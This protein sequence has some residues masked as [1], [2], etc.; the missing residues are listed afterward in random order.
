MS[1]NLDG[2]YPIF[3]SARLK[4]VRPSNCLKILP[5]AVFSLLTALALF[6]SFHF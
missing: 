2:K 5:I 3:L 6:H 1:V 4:V